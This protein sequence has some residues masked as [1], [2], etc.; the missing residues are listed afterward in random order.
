MARA[1]HNSH[2]VRR[3]RAR[4]AT[5]P[6][7]RT[8][9]RI[10]AAARA[11]FA[12]RGLEMASIRAITRLA[13]VNA[14]L[15]SYYFGSKRQLYE[16][17]LNDCTMQLNYPRL[18]ALDEL[19]RAAGGGPVALDA[20]VRTFA[21]PY[22]SGL[23]DPHSAASVYLRFFGRLFTEPSDDLLA[24]TRTKF[25]TLQRRFVAAFARALPHVP[26]RDLY[27]RF[28]YLIGSTS[29]MSVH[30]GILEQYSDGE[31]S[32]RDARFWDDYV[33]TWCD[34]LAAPAPVRASR[35][36]SAKPARQQALA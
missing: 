26:R 6:A 15:I 25:N 20:L 7:E 9:E 32:T 33:R 2:P 12:E 34:L 1:L 24:I 10:L 13:G 23:D 18:A 8:R 4:L 30:T 31:F 21:S 29:Y 19:E 16:E 14:A 22:I 17:V 11:H 36:S 35:R 3:P 27:L 28:S 5:P